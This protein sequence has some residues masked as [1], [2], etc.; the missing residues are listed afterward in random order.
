MGDTQ[1]AVQGSPMVNMDSRLPYC[2]A[3][4]GANSTEIT[5]PG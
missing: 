3:I 2:R 1:L 5:Q 4:L